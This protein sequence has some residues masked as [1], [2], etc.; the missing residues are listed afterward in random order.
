MRWEC[1]MFAHVWCIAGVGCVAKQC[2]EH[3]SI[4]FWGEDCINYMARLPTCISGFPVLFLQSCAKSFFFNSCALVHEIFRSIFLPCFL[5]VKSIL[6]GKFGKLD[7]WLI[8][9]SGSKQVTTKNIL[10]YF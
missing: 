8:E 10:F 2:F 5:V 4:L 6:S 3:S 9:F 1:G 7:N